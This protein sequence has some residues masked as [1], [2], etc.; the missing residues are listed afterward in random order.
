[1]NLRVFGCRKYR[2]LYYDRRDR[3]LSV[4]EQGFMS[5]HEA[6]C[7]NCERRMQI[8]VVALNMLRQEALEGCA[9]PNFEDRVLRRFRVETVRGSFGYWSPAVLGAAVAGLVVLA[10]LQ[11]IAQP[12]RL[13]SFQVRSGE[14]RLSSPAFPNLS[15][16]DYHSVWQ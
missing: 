15:N 4:R 6:V 2:K 3:K 1:M 11:M 16:S 10:A 9:R 12:S 13:P 14:A 8:A 7:P 5:K